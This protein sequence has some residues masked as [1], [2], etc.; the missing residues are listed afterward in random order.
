M[1]G[2]L[3]KQ[4]IIFKG[5]KILKD[6]DNQAYSTYKFTAVVAE[7][8]LFSSSDAINV[9]ITDDEKR[10]PLYIEAN[11]TVGSVKIFHNGIKLKTE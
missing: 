7:H 1:D 6:K 9:W 3:R 2:E 4:K 10:I 8:N 5:K 11:L